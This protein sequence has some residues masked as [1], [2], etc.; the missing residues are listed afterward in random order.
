M[1]V[2]EVSRIDRAAGKRE[3]RWSDNGLI[4]DLEMGGVA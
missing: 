3:F 2:R 4:D 1:W